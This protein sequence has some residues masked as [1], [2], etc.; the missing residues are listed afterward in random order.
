[1]S[2]PHNSSSAAAIAKQVSEQLNRAQSLHPSLFS[3]APNSKQ[4]AVNKGSKARN[5]VT[6]LSRLNLMPLAIQIFCSMGGVTGLLA[7][8][9]GGLALK[10][11]SFCGLKF[12]GLFT[13]RWKKL[14]D[15][16]VPVGAAVGEM[17]SK[18]PDSTWSTIAWVASKGWDIGTNIGQV[19]SGPFGAPDPVP[20]VAPQIIILPSSQQA[21]EGSAQQAAQAVLPAIDP[22]A[23]VGAVHAFAANPTA[24]TFFQKIVEIAPPQYAIPLGIATTFFICYQ[25]QY[26]HIFGVLKDAGEAFF[27]YSFQVPKF[28][29]T[30][31][32]VSSSNVIDFAI[33]LLERLES[34][35]EATEEAGY[36]VDASGVTVADNDV[37][38]PII[39]KTCLQHLDT[40]T[41]QDIVLII[42]AGITA[43]TVTY[44]TV[45][46]TYNRFIKRTEPKL[47]PEATSGIV[48]TIKETITG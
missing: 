27:K 43:G 22:Q 26:V 10:A 4:N 15:V 25:P 46:W 34:V 23:V 5:V 3:P 40:L 17:E 32:P 33:D 20:Q 45:K 29:R 13:S 2:V 38:T 28:V 39:H 9:S 41:G 7:G 11:I 30:P 12:I 24:P 6:F 47:D 37:I 8:K 21:I 31:M 42:I 19:F 14:L 18:A 16:A 1:M 48:E 35:N 36:V 44:Y